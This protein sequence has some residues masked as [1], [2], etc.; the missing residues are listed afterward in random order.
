MC[1]INRKYL[2]IALVSVAFV[3]MGL[4]LWMNGLILNSLVQYIVG[5]SLAVF[6]IS[7]YSWA[8]SKIT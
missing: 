2:A 4:M 6:C 1:K 5:T 7:S 8:I 3:G